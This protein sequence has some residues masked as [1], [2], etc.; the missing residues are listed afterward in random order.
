[1]PRMIPMKRADI[2]RPVTAP[3]CSGLDMVWM[4]TSISVII[5][6]N[7]SPITNRENPTPVMPRGIR[8]KAPMNPM[9]MT[10]DPVRSRGRIP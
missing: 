8:M 3:S 6:P 10:I 9:A 7:P 4:L 1:M 5:S 2:N